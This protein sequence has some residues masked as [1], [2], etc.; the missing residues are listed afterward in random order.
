MGDL[1]NT[2]TG[3]EFLL[4][5]PFVLFEVRL[6]GLLDGSEMMTSFGRTVRP[7]GDTLIWLT[8]LGRKNSVLEWLRHL[9]N[10]LMAFGRYNRG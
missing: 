1:S 7:V 5:C 8:P 9:R 10:L 3:D 6:V 4:G 2:G